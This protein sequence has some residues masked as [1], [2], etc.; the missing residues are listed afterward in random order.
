MATVDAKYM[1]AIVGIVR[2]SINFQSFRFEKI[3][4]I[5]WIALEKNSFIVFIFFVKNKIP[6]GA[7]QKYNIFYREYEKTLFQEII[8]Y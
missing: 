7:L 8:I 3:P 5:A 6:I 1:A 2:T 4:L